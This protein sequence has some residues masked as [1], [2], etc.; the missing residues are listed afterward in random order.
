MK[1]WQTINIFVCKIN[2]LFRF[3]SVMLFCCLDPEPSEVGYQFW[4]KKGIPNTDIPDSPP[5]EHLEV[6][7][8]QRRKSPGHLNASPEESN[9]QPPSA[10]RRSS[11]NNGPKT[12]NGT[13]NS[14]YRAKRSDRYSVAELPRLMDVA[15]L[16]EPK[17]RSRRLP[18]RGT[19]NS[20]RPVESK[21]PDVE[22]LRLGLDRSEGEDTVGDNDTTPVNQLN[23]SSDPLEMNSKHTNNGRSNSLPFG[24]KENK[25]PKKNKFKRGM[26]ISNMRR[27]SSK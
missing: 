23:P 18:R 9:P 3:H 26:S 21:K 27:S 24:T 19:V 16:D 12:G 10:R 25:A 5:N 15:Q 13:G 14:S 20:I 11:Q 22:A 6:K 17:T 2:P 4:K 8:K 1:L 7:L